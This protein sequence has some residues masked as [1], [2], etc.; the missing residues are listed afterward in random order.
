MQ[1]T[2]IK[3]NSPFSCDQYHYKRPRLAREGWKNSL[4]KVG[5]LPTSSTVA[6]ESSYRSCRTRRLIWHSVSNC[7]LCSLSPTPKH[8]FSVRLHNRI[9]WS[10]SQSLNEDSLFLLKEN[11]ATNIRYDIQRPIMHT[12]DLANQSAWSPVTGS[13]FEPR[14]PWNARVCPGEDAGPAELSENPRYGRPS[15]GIV[16]RLKSSSETLKLK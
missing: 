5:F 14:K 2:C 16:R 10:V 1:L 6:V 8:V 3:L 12:P 7:K 11:Y 9:W 13:E 4:G 15:W